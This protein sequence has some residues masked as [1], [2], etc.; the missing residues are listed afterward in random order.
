MT[1]IPDGL[2][3]WE[4]ARGD[5]TVGFV[6]TET[7]GLSTSED[8]VVELGVV[9]VEVERST[10]RIASAQ[11][12][13]TWLRKPATAL[14]AH[15]RAINGID[16]AALEHPTWDAGEIKATLGRCEWLIAHNAGFDRD[17]VERFGDSDGQARWACTRE[18]AGWDGRAGGKKSLE[19]L[20]AAA[21]LW[22]A[23]HRAGA[24]A[25]A[26]AALTQIAALGGGG[27][28]LLAE[29]I[30]RA[31]RPSTMIG[32]EARVWPGDAVN[33]AL[34]R[35]GLRHDVRRRTWWTDARTPE[36]AAEVVACIA[37]HWPQG[38]VVRAAGSPRT[39]YRGQ[40]RWTSR[41]TVAQARRRMKE[42]APERA[43]GGGDAGTEREARAFR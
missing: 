39:R 1:P 10:G 9:V 41:E 4:D 22:F 17:F 20:C 12:P 14:S 33:A 32:M 36:H 5:T 2:P 34:R 38:T 15:V 28:R 24:D 31:A 23:A 43:G 42:T 25:Q 35:E 18:D 37:R 3:E 29:I 6:D 7:T 26:C 19:W 11:A 21:G 40:P 16:D 8:E 13:R 30:E 27:R